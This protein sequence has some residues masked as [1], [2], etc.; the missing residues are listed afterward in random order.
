MLVRLPGSGLASQHLLDHI[1]GNGGGTRKVELG[2][3]VFQRNGDAGMAKKGALDRCGHGARIKHVDAGVGA[4]VHAADDKIRRLASSS[5]NA[6]FTQS[7]GLPSTAQPRKCL[8]S[9]KISCTTNGVS[10]VIE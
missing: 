3:L 9:S 8:S 2:L 6:S 10:K 5:V 1:A 4:G 7:A